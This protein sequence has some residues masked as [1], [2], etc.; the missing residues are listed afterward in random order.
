MNDYIISLIRTGVGLVVGTLV[1]W[2]VA[3][4]FVDADTAETAATSISAGAFILVNALWY[5]L[6]RWIEDKTGWPLFGV[7]KTPEY[8]TDK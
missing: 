3:Q 8:P 6:A 4:G 7:S 2:L 1:G 5:A